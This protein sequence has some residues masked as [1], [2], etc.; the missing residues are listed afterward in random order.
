MKIAQLEALLA[1]RQRTFDTL[2]KERDALKILVEQQVEK[3]AE[4]ERNR[5][6]PLEIYM[7]RVAQARRQILERM[8]DGLRL[9]FPD[10]QVQLSEQSDA[11]R[12]NDAPNALQF[13]LPVEVVRLKKLQNV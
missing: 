6:D 12:F 5:N 1:D 7:G 11:L 2:T 8:R 10:L 9:D 13:L 3:I 4:L